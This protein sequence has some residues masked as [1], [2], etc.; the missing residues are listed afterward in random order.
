ML[1]VDDRDRLASP[2]AFSTGLW[3]APPASLLVFSAGQNDA[4]R[5]RRMLVGRG[6][7]EPVDSPLRAYALTCGG[8]S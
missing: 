7:L 5:P 4:G 1:G 2:Q 8:G 6:G 3:N